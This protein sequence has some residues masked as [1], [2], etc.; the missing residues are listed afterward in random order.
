MAGGVLLQSAATTGNGNEW[1]CRGEEGTYTLTVVGAGTISAGAVQWEEALEPGYAGTWAAL[2]SAI[3]VVSG[4]VIRQAFSGNPQH[5][6]ARI[7]TNIAGG[8]SV[9]VKMQPPLVGG[10]S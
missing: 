8:G 7:S 2:G 5:V 1:N 6:R 10:E 9:T 3:S 4:Q